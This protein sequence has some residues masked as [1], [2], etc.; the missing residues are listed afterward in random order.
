MSL[1]TVQYQQKV[2]F[3]C[4]PCSHEKMCKFVL[5]NVHTLNVI[6]LYKHIYI[7]DKNRGKVQKVQRT[8][9]LICI[10]TVY[11]IHDNELYS[12]CRITHLYTEHALLWRVFTIA[13]VQNTRIHMIDGLMDWPITT[14]VLY[15]SMFYSTRRGPL[16]TWRY[17]SIQETGTGV[18]NQGIIQELL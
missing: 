14:D 12:K 8:S 18:W 5:Y 10:C 1:Y 15:G 7:S 2:Y 4:Q 3:F 6:T 17:I 9:N 16:W 13:A 11:T